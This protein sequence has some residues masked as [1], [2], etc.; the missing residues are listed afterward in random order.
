MGKVIEIKGREVTENLGDAN[1]F[2]AKKYEDQ[3][4][5]YDLSDLYVPVLMRE[6]TE[7]KVVMRTV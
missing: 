4:Q 1:L 3:K 5:T 6:K 7:N 2:G